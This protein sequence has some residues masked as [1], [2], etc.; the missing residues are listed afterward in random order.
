MTIESEDRAVSGAKPAKVRRRWRN[1]VVVGLVLCALPILAGLLV[2]VLWTVPVVGGLSLLSPSQ[3]PTRGMFYF[4]DSVRKV[5]WSMHVVKINRARK[6]FE[7]HSMI[8]KGRCMGMTTIPEQVA[9]L[10]PEWGQ[11]VA[12]VNGDLYNNHPDYPG[13]PEG[14]QIVHGE[15][16][17]APS[18]DH[19]S[20]W[21]DPAGNP[22]RGE[23]ISNFAVIWADGSTTPL[24]L[25]EARTNG[26]AVLY[27][28]AVGESTRAQGGLELV[29]E[30]EGDSSWLPL[31]VG[32]LYAVRVREVH[33]TG[34]S[35]VPREVMV[36]SLGPE[37]TGRLAKIEVG[38]VL[39]ISTATTPDLKGSPTALGGGP[40]LVVNGKAKDW[41]GLRFRHPR[42]AIG[43][44]QD[45]LFLVEVDGRQLGLSAGMTL[46]E[47]AE[48]MAKLGCEEAMNLDGGGSATCWVYGN[49]MNSP[50]QGRARPAANGLVLLQKGK[51]QK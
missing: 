9:Q 4:H 39:K 7:L 29:L 17:S 12:A 45:Y 41:P 24:G 50:S 23:V 1:V 3:R 15:L 33:P 16:V 27:T 31:A 37:L 25:N 47:L 51:P 10:P 6:D 49:V 35:P 8:G 2:L 11:P 5:P 21:I 48:Y 32:Q 18:A 26:G 30:R 36:L 44:N 22:H 19:V 20:L 42:T 28:A 40:S 34:N 43:W 38:A 46:S 13:D 14:L